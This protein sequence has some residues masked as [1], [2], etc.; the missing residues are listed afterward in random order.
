MPMIVISGLSSF[1]APE[2][3]L[4]TLI[5][6]AAIMNGVQALQSGIG[7]AIGS[8]RNHWRFIAI[9]LVGILISAQLVRVLPQWALFLAIGVPVTFFATLQLL[10]WALRFTPS[11]RRV[12]EL[13]LGGVA[14]MMGGLSGIWGPPTVLYL[15]ALNIAKQESLRI[16]G[17]VYGAG[18][19]T[20]MGA[21]VQSGVLNLQTLPFSLAMIVPTGIGLAIGMLYG[22]RLDQQ[23]FR[24]MTLLVL[25]LVGLNLIRRGIMG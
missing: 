23:K 17:V 15:T 22:T 13:G 6:P 21:H 9:G 5:I 24:R 20:L 10:G 25:V 18:A 2:L 3:A 7:A 4:A 19:V 8:A 14:G 16:Q 1:A 12:A 11:Q